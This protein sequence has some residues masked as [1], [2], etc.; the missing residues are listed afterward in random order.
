VGFFFIFL[1]ASAFLSSLKRAEESSI[2]RRA[3][4][5]ASSS[6][7]SIMPGRC[8]ALVASNAVESKMLT[9]IHFSPSSHSS[10]F[11]SSLLFW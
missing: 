2:D 11:S 7:L 3:L 1:A 5:K 10:V 9:H 6:C 4:I 8:S